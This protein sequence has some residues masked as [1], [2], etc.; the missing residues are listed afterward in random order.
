[1]ENNLEDFY[2]E[3]ITL[4]G[5]DILKHLNIKPKDIPKI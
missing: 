1:M 3:K 5:N 4:N 2:K